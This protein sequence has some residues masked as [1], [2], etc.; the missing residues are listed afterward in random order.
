MLGGRGGGG[1]ELEHASLDGQ[2]DPSV[3][4]PP[5]ALV[6]GEPLGERQL[7]SCADEAADRFTALDVG[8]LVVR[9]VPL[10]VFEV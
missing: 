8:E 4:E 3:D 1:E 5:E 7:G 9:A 6:G 10:G 2:L